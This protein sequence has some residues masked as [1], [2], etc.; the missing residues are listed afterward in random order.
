MTF[1][2]IIVS[3][4]MLTILAMLASCVVLCLFL[5]ASSSIGLGPKQSLLSHFG[6]CVDCYSLSCIFT[7]LAYLPERMAGDLL[8]FADIGQ[9]RKAVLIDLPSGHHL[10]RLVMC[11]WGSVRLI[12]LGAYR[13]SATVLDSE[14][15]TEV[16]IL[17]LNDIPLAVVCFDLFS[18]H[19]CGAGVS[20]WSCY[21]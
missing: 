16:C 2:L 9:A 1:L 21:D 4:S 19:E 10:L 8:D 13:M 5:L 20:F 17:H 15:S 18:G 6:F 7:T 3:Q 12:T 14:P 11:K